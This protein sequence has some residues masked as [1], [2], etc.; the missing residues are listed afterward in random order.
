[1][2]FYLFVSELKVSNI[3]NMMPDFGFCRKE[4][5]L[6]LYPYRFIAILIAI[7]NFDKAQA[8]FALGQVEGARA[9]LAEK[10]NSWT[11]RSG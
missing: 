5:L 7:N 1:M 2:C 8:C 3:C 6:P 9:D 4:A 11:D 10:R